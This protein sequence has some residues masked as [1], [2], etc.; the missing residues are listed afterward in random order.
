MKKKKKSWWLLLLLMTLLLVAATDNVIG[1]EVQAVETTG[2]IGFTGTYV[3][4]GTPDPTPPVNEPPPVTD[5]AKPGGSLPQT[6]NVNQSWLVWLGMILLSFVFLYAN[7]QN[8]KPTKNN[9]KAGIIQ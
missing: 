6:N 7:K 8:E 1:S 3:P 5:S 9:K 2:N 4:I